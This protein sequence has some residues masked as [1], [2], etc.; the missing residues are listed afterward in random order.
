MY[1]LSQKHKY[2]TKRN[3]LG[4]DGILHIKHLSEKVF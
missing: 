3:K 2:F 1:I 4:S